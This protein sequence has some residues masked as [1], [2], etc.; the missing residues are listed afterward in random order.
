M[1]IEKKSSE[2]LTILAASK[3][4]DIEPFPRMLADAK[5]AWQAIVRDNDLK[6]IFRDA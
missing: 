5:E 3:L 4:K 2:E 1:K 6:K